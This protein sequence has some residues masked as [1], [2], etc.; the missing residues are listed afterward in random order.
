M[1]AH[2]GGMPTGQALYG[3]L[4]LLDEMSEQRA[5]M[6]QYGTWADPMTCVAVIALAILLVAVVTALV[7]NRV[8]CDPCRRDLPWI[9]AAFGAIVVIG[10]AYMI[11]IMHC[12][13]VDAEAAY[14]EARDYY[15][16]WYT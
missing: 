4:E 1:D 3:Q 8:R 13:Y 15:R 10:I 7:H 9:V 11:W 12:G 5:L 2:R 6:E 16:L 14:L